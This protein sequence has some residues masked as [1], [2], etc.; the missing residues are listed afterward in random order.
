MP[1]I[2][3]NCGTCE[4][5]VPG[6]DGDTCAYDGNKVTVDWFCRHWEEKE[7]GSDG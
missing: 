7:D 5:R 2:P 4:F 6:A 1:V 3:M